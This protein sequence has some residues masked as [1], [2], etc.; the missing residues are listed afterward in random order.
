[1]HHFRSRIS[2]QDRYRAE[3]S[4]AWHSL[5]LC[6]SSGA[7]VLIGALFTPAPRIHEW[8]SSASAS[9]TLWEQEEE[10]MSKA[11]QL[12]L[13]P[14]PLPAL[15]IE[16]PAVP[17]T[18]SPLGGADLPP[19]LPIATES[20]ASDTLIP[21]P[22]TLGESPRPHPRTK[23]AASSPLPRQEADIT[24]PSY[25]DAPEP[26]Y[27]PTLRAERAEG[28]VRVRIAIDV[29]GNPTRVDIVQSSGHREFDT[30][31]RE[32][33]MQRWHFSPAL[34]GGR[35]IARVVSTSICFVMQ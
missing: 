15:D 18:I 27:P 25:R 7:A 12:S 11:P 29:Q 28:S 17:P 13:Q 2:A 20:G 5:F 24:P 8:E 33:I 16:I 14:P 31:A 9:I 10:P 35:P 4:R 34:C 22:E 19:G 26:P 6:A 23:T 21:A 32:W 3:T 1:M 30:T